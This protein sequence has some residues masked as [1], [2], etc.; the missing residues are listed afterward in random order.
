MFQITCDL[1]TLTADERQYI[2]QFISDYPTLDASE[3]NIIPAFSI[4]DDDDIDEPMTTPEASFGLAIVPP[5]PPTTANPAGL[6][7]T[8]LPWDDRI[9]SSNKAFVADGTWRK[10]RGVDDAFV[11]QVEAELRVIMNIPAAPL[12]VPSDEAPMAQMYNASKVPAPPPIPAAPVVPY[13]IVALADIPAP[14]VIPPPPP[15]APG[16]SEPNAYLNLIQLVTDVCTKKQLT[17]EQVDEC[18]KSVD[19]S[20]NLQL[21]SKRPDLIPQIAAHIRTLAA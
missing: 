17:R 4:P 14:V 18:I 1:T 13:P 20:L 15:V 6:D 9:H 16:V 10:R 5:P 21:L 8:G 2:A 3:V 19:A 12:N 7:K 11:A